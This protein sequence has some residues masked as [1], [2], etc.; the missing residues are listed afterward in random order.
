MQV[1]AWTL[2]LKQSGHL[3]SQCFKEFMLKDLEFEELSSEPNL[4]RKVLKLEDGAMHELL[5]GTYVDDCVIAASS[6]AARQ[7]YLSRLSKRFPVNPKSTGIISFAEPGRILS[8]QVRYDIEK[9]I[10]EFDQ[11][12]AIEALA[13]KLGVEKRK[14]RSLPIDPNCDLP[15]LKE[16]EADVTDYMSII[17]SCLHIAQVSRPDIAF[18]MGVLSRHSATPG[19]KHMEAA[20]DLVSYLLKT[21]HLFIGY[22]RTKESVNVPTIYEKSKWAGDISPVPKKSIEERL[23][24]SVPVPEPNSPDMFCDA[25]YAGDKETRRSTSGM[26]VMMNGGPISWSSRLQKLVALS[27]AES[28]IY[29]VA[30]SVKEA[31]HVKLMCEDC[32]LREPGVPMTVWEDNAAAIHLGHGLRGNNKQKHFAV[33]LRFLWEHIHCKNIE[34]AKIG[35]GDQLADALTKQLPGP[36]FIKFRNQILK[37]NKGHRAT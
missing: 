8:M 26:I 17:G 35:T 6:E 18:A 20:L 10:L 25:D 27:S 24:A 1:R 7:W 31:L 22:Q 19:E 36:A 30:D 5:V 29:A 11:M 2:R 12:E 33:R 16:A 14:P 21:K 32:G 34:F 23:M 13:K 28:E 9:G 15:K 4:Y 3:W 37:S